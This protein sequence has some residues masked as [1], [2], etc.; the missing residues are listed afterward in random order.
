[1]TNSNERIWPPNTRYSVLSEDGEY[2]P[3]KSPI[4]KS[5]LQNE[6]TEPIYKNAVEYGSGIQAFIEPLL[7]HYQLMVY[8]TP[9]LIPANEFVRRCE[10]DGWIVYPTILKVDTIISDH[11]KGYEYRIYLRRPNNEEL[12]GER[13]G[14]ICD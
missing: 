12:L 6:I 5:F 13:L 2:Y 14:G 1:M 10:S 7:I 8:R 11:F 9:E 3:T 4:S